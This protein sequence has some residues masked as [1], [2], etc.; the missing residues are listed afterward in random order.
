MYRNPRGVYLVLIMS[1]DERPSN[2]LQA[3][4]RVGAAWGAAQLYWHPLP[5][6]AL[7]SHPRDTRL[8]LFPWVMLYPP[9]FFLSDLLCGC[10]DS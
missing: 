4:A 7:P 5:T 2:N 8:H 1:F 3:G 6:G 10:F 9:H